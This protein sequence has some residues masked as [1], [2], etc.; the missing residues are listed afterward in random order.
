MAR[1]VRGVEVDVVASTTADVERYREALIGATT[2]HD[3]CH[4]SMTSNRVASGRSRA[5]SGPSD[6]SRWESASGLE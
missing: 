4:R 5:R 6:R 2:T 1:L 3:G